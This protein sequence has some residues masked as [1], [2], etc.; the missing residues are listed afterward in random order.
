MEP[1]HN[2]EFESGAK[3]D[4]V[5]HSNTDG[6]WSLI[7]GSDGFININE[8][9]ADDLHDE[10]WIA[11]NLGLFHYDK[12]TET[13]EEVDAF[14]DAS[15]KSLAISKDGNVIIGH[16]TAI[17]VSNDGGETFEIVSTGS[18]TPG[19]INSDGVTRLE[20]GISHEKVDGA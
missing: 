4:G 16:G 8:I 6:T 17:R 1:R 11:T 13:L 2:G 5:F 20:F 10:I 9:V 18:E 14:S 19:L 3:G 15:C 7:P 12:G